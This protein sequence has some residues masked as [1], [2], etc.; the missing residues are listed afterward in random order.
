MRNTHLFAAL[1]LCGLLLHVSGICGHAQTVTW[2]HPGSLTNNISPDGTFASSP[3][4]AMDDNNNIIV[5]WTQDTGS[6]TEQVFKSEYRNGVWTNP[7]SLSDYVSNATKYVSGARVAMNN[8]GDAIIVWVQYSSSTNC[9]VYK[10]E[11]HNG[12]WGE[13][14]LVSAT[15]KSI[16]TTEVAM[17]DSGNIV[18][19]WDQNIGSSTGSVLFTNEYRNGSWSGTTQLTDFTNK[20]YISDFSLAMGNNGSTVIVWNDEINTGLTPINNGVQYYIYT[21][22]TYRKNYRNND[23]QATSQAGTAVTQTTTKS[24]LPQVAINDSGD[25]VIIWRKYVTGDVATYADPKGIFASRYSYSND[26]WTDE[27]IDQTGATLDQASVAMNN[28]GKILATWSRS[29]AS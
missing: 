10:C 26:T 11:Y 18:I 28:N 12:S 7:A 6:N 25:A 16:D 4:V 15:G 27:T 24:S 23:W 22:K 21:Y 19:A 2:T 5:V 13:P 1:M 8:N 17:D 14:E 20:Y 29:A 3:R 9:A